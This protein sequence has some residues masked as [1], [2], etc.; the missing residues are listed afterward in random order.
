MNKNDLLKRIEER[1]LKN[2]IVRI[3][4]W[5]AEIAVRE[6]NG[7]RLLFLSKSCVDSKGN[8]D[9][10]KFYVQAIVDSVYTTDE[11][12]GEQLF[13]N[14]DIELIENLPADIFSKL[15]QNIMSINNIT[16]SKK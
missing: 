7:S 9:E 1:K 11:E 2:Y 16:N 14:K 5:D 6:L 10:N 3:E 15:V 12:G 4:D 13:T 8:I